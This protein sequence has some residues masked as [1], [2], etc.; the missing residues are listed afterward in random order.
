[1]GGTCDSVG[2]GGCWL[3]GCFGTWS[4]LYGSG[5]HNLVQAR[6]VLADGSLVT[7]NACRNAELF[8]ALRG[9]GGGTFGVVTEF[10]AR[11]HAPPTTVLMGS[12]SFTAHGEGAFVDALGALLNASVAFSAPPWGGGIGFGRGSAND[13]FTVSLGPK[14]FDATPAQFA[15]LAAPFLAFA[16]RDPARF[17][18]ARSSTSEWRSDSGSPLPWIE[19]HPDREISTQLVASMSV[20]STARQLRTPA[21]AAAVARARLQT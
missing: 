17:S 2:V 14:G 15:E 8:W 11:T 10:V 4:K 18:D 6:V 13:T 20:W 9:G 5:A 21:R 1:M 12:A 3:G 16:A 19:V 7:A